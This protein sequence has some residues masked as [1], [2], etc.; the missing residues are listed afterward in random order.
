MCFTPCSQD[1]KSKTD[2]VLVRWVILTVTW[3]LA[4]G[5]K[6]SSEAIEQ[7]SHFFHL[8]AW[9]G[10][11]VLT[12]AVLA[13]GKI[14]GDIL[15]GVCYVGLSDVK[16]LQAFV[17]APLTIFL[18]LGTLFLVLGFGS[19]FRIRTIIKHGGTKTDKLEKLM[20]RIGVF[21]VMYFIPSIIVVACLFY[22][23][24]YFDRWMLSW[25]DRI[26]MQPS[27]HY[28][29]VNCQSQ[30]SHR[31]QTDKPNF[32]VFLLKYAMSMVVGIASGFWIWSGKTLNSW[33]N[34]YRY[35]LCCPA[36]PEFAYRYESPAVAAAD[37]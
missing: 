13:M 11:A 25:W 8:I 6:W 19:L 33:S 17:L 16:T 24:H 35:V 29:D 14:D 2:F 9:A 7:N 21:S 36:Q 3:F 34:F 4:A 26:C 10:P 23:Q 37:V 18:L 1:H 15:A 32:T 31:R 30:Q 27:T 12:I 20:I 22:E 5:L 28:K